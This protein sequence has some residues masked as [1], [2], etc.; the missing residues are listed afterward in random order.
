MFICKY[1]NMNMYVYI[2]KYGVFVSLFVCMFVCM[3]ACT[4]IYIFIHT[5]YIYIKNKKI[6]N[7][8]V[9]QK[10]VTIAVTSNNG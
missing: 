4:Y 10:W 9:D 3:H 8:Q 6:N 7:P 2:C 1:I 5:L